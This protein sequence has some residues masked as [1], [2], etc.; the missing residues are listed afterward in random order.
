MSDVIP[1]AHS[2]ATA[3]RIAYLAGLPLIEYDRVRQQEAQALGVR[4]GTLDAEVARLRSS[5]SEAEAR[6]AAVAPNNEPGWKLL[7]DVGRHYCRFVVMNDAQARVCSLWTVHTY[8]MEAA[9]Y[10]PYLYVHSPEKQSGKT[11]LFDVANQ[12]VNNPDRTDDI[13][14]AAIVHKIDRLAPTL[15]LDELD[16]TF[17]GDKERAEILR[18]VLNSGFARTGRYTRMV[19]DGISM[20]P[21]DF[22]TFCPKALAGIG[23]LPDT[24]ADR[25][26]PIGLVRKRRDEH[27]ERFRERKV[28]VQAAPLRDR[29]AGWVATHLDVLRCAEPELPEAL[30]DRQQD[31]VEPLLAIADAAGGDW[32][33]QARRALVEI[34]AGRPA[35]DQSDGVQLLSDIHLI[36]TDRGMDRISSTDLSEALVGL[37]GRPWAE[38]ANGKPITPNRLARLLSRYEIGPRNVRDGAAQY[39]GYEL[40]WFQD[41]FARYLPLRPSHQSRTAE[42]VERSGA[43]AD[44]AQFSKASRMGD[45]TVAKSEESPLFVRAGTVGTVHPASVRPGVQERHPNAWDEESL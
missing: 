21:R 22:S 36:F 11:R 39:K 33:E 42:V 13:S 5:K 35:E 41:A 23:R 6:P 43:C 2:D 8:A 7:D 28:A 3:E 26:I 45:G 1:S 20:E 16:A 31:V 19:G 44:V 27:V 9:H 40:A 4:V 34:F 25:S 18:G 15:L 17:K 29:I 14:P 24:I 10:T 38:F 32:P 12:L 30:T 37:E